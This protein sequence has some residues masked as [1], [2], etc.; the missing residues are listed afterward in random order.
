MQT[1]LLQLRQFR[2][3]VSDAMSPRMCPSYF[4][5]YL[6]VF[7]D[8]TVF[9][10]NPTEFPDVSDPSCKVVEVQEPV[11]KATIIVPDCMKSTVDFQ[12]GP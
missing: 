3:K 5:R 8:R 7:R 10:S 12:I 2:I 4:T 9:V 6:V 1:L 11:E